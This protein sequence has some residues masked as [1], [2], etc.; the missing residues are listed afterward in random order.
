MAADRNKCNTPLPIR[1]WHWLHILGVLTL[2]L[3][4]A[5]IRFAEYVHLFPSFRTA[6]KVHNE[7]GLL[8]TVSFFL[9]F[10][11]YTTLTSKLGST[12]LLHKGEVRHGLRQQMAHYFVHFFRGRPD[13]H[14]ATP[15][16]RF[17]PLEKTLYMLVMLILFP[18][19]MITGMALK[20]LYP[21]WKVIDLFGS[22]K[23]LMGLHFLGGCLLCAFLLTH[24]YLTT[25]NSTAWPWLRVMF[26]G[27]AA[28]EKQS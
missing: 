12:Y 13:P 11:Y 16:S 5:Q 7:A 22:I 2:I 8:V 17:N 27:R 6:I 25:L 1:L 19:Q 4:G 24:V 21:P 3:S 15:Q 20:S 26:K 9:W 18:L 23:F 28:I 10:F 14:Q